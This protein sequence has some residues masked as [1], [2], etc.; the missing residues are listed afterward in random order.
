MLP[1]SW[2]VHHLHTPAKASP[3]PQAHH[4]LSDCSTSIFH[5]LRRKCSN[6]PRR[7]APCCADSSAYPLDRLLCENGV[8]IGDQL[9][10]VVIH[11]DFEML[12][13]DVEVRLTV[14]AFLRTNH[15]ILTSAECTKFKECDGG[16]GILGEHEDVHVRV[17]LSLNLPHDLTTEGFAVLALLPRGV[18]IVAA[19]VQ[20]EDIEIIEG[21]SYFLLP[22]H[23]RALVDSSSQKDRVF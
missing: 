3:D 19:G 15:G 21:T 14:E 11:G 2:R 10:E 22:V 12:G 23:R 8:Q 20:D 7:I 6:H 17:F 9:V 18:P 13:V 1:R 16:L 4:R 5:N